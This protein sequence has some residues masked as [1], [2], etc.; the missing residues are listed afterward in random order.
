[1][2]EKTAKDTVTV[3]NICKMAKEMTKTPT[4][5]YKYVHTLVVQLILYAKKLQKTLMT[6]GIERALKDSIYERSV[7]GVAELI[8]WLSGK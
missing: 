2:S 6:M 1:M 7:V 8:K 5:I 3:I 4:T